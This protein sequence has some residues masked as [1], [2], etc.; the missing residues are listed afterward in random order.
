LNKNYVDKKA[1]EQHLQDIPFET[2]PEGDLKLKFIKVI[3]VDGV[4]KFEK[5]R[6]KNVGYPMSPEDSTHRNFVTAAINRKYD[7]L[8]FKVT[9]SGD[10]KFTTVEIK[11]SDGSTTTKKRKLIGFDDGPSS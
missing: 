3:G 1:F 11:N 10:I 4:E 2:T 8:P 9:N 7:E 6:V 5:R